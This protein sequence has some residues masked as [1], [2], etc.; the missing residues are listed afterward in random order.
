MVKYMEL[1][2]K[3]D[4]KSTWYLTL[5]TEDENPEFA[6]QPINGMCGDFNGDGWSKYTIPLIIILLLLFSIII[7]INIIIIIVFIIIIRLNY[8]IIDVEHIHRVKT[9]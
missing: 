5:D 9:I 6:N 8:A 1:S 4:A 2:A 3:W 7:T